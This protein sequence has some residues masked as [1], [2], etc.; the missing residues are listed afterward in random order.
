MLNLITVLI[1]GFEPL[2]NGV[3]ARF[4]IEPDFLGSVKLFTM[5]LTKAFWMGM[6]PIDSRDLR[7]R[8]L[9]KTSN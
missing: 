9:M 4:F 1:L 6:I 7:P 3:V 8:Q 5:K 2:F